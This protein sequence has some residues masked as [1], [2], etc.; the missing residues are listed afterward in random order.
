MIKKG[1]EAVENLAR[2]SSIEAIKRTVE[3]LIA[4]SGI[5]IPEGN[6]R[7]I[8]TKA[9]F[10][11]GTLQRCGINVLRDGAGDPRVDDVI[12]TQWF[13]DQEANLVHIKIALPRLREKY[14]R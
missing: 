9:C 2:Y 6:M 10:F 13:R 12:N 5:V 1:L 3:K 8:Y 11:L 4:V 14:Q 7:N